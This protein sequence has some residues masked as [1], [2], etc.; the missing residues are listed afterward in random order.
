[1]HL[2]TNRTQLPARVQALVGDARAPERRHFSRQPLP[3]RRHAVRNFPRLP[4][5]EV[6]PDRSA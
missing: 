3:S 2:N 5:P 6:R 1:M 4:E